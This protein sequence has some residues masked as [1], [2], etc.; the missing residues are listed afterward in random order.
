[1]LASV[2]GIVA[3]R[4]SAASIAPAMDVLPGTKADKE[5]K[6][7]AGAIAAYGSNET[8]HEREAAEHAWP[9]AHPNGGPIRRASLVARDGQSLEQRSI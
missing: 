6:D 8:Q 3:R 1:M 9:L 4:K 2:R 7:T 5:V